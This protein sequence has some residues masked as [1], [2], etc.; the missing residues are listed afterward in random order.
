MY[1]L[2]R[3]SILPKKFFGSLHPKFR[4]PVNNII[5]VSIIS[6]LALVISL[7]MA[8][9]FVSFGALTS[10]AFV[11]ISVIVECFIKRK[12]RSLKQTFQYLIFPL[13]G[14]SF[15]IWLITLLDTQ[16]LLLG[17][18]WLVFGVTYYLIRT[19]KTRE[20][21]TTANTNSIFPASAAIES[22]LK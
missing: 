5:L 21:H 17:C 19:R 2:G 22:E 15:I 1:V 4:T 12:Q 20:S 10:F 8:V 7:D 9:K 16:A 18:V 6:L 13:I 14:A 11:N 3:D